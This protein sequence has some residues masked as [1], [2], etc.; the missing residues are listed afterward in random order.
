MATS[1]PEQEKAVSLYVGNEDLTEGSYSFTIKVTDGK[2]QSVSVEKTISVAAGCCFPAGTLIN[3]SDE[4]LRSIEELKAG[5]KVLSYNLETKQI[6]EDEI[7]KCANRPEQY[8]FDVILE[9]NSVIHVTGNHKFY[10]SEDGENYSYHM[11]TDIKEGNYLFNKENSPV[12]ILEIRVHEENCT[13]YDISTKKNH[14]YY[15]CSHVEQTSERER[16]KV[17]VHNAQG[18]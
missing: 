5:D 12:K 13:V 4:S 10:V 1:S 7:V 8:I 16:E 15:V 9:D 2:N 6:E 18:C 11:L 17:L 14:N 3:M